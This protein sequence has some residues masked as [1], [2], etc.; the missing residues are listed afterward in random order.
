MWYL[1]VS[2]PDLCNLTYFNHIKQA[3]YA[4]LIVIISYYDYYVNL[5]NAHF[6]TFT[7]LGRTLTLGADVSSTLSIS[8]C[9]MLTSKGT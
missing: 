4:F 7:V 2:F 6:E 3:V 1:I 5:G 9:S 8:R